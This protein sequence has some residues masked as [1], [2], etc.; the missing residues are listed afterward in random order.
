MSER[1]DPNSAA[2]QADAQ[3]CSIREMVAALDVDY[4]RLEE[5]RDFLE[6]TH[7]DQAGSATFSEWLEA[8][9]KEDD[10]ALDER[11][12]YVELLAA[13]G[14]R[15][16]SDD[17]EDRIREDALSVEVRS[18]WYSPHRYGDDDEPAEFRIVLCTGG[19]HVE[20]RGGL[21]NGSPV[22]AYLHYKDWGTCGDRVNKKGDRDTLIRYASIFFFRE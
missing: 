7:A 4:D 11:N 6:E 15:E 22:D 20:I 21:N 1:N 9:W 17:A 16:S 18:G 19:P 3:M 2:G 5:L 12:E 10:Y 14:E 8:D 13:A